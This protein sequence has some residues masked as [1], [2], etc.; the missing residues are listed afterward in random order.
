MLLFTKEGTCPPLQTNIDFG[1]KFSSVLET[2]GKIPINHLMNTEELKR[3]NVNK[4]I[5]LLN[6]CM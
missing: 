2:Q 1:E 4:C 6:T 3:A 5:I